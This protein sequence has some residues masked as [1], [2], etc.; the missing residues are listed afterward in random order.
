MLFRL[1]NQVIH[2][3]F[4]LIIQKGAAIHIRKLL[5]QRIQRMSHLGHI[6]TVL[7]GLMSHIVKH[8][9]NAVVIKNLKQTGRI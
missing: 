2:T 7:S 1:L 8:Y 4:I 9:L 3:F 5:G 6:G